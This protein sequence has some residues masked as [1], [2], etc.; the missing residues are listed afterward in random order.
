MD[1]KELRAYNLGGSEYVLVGVIIER[2]GYS[3]HPTYGQ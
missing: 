3:I 1:L 2:R